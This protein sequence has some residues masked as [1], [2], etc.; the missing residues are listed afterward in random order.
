MLQQEKG[1]TTTEN[2]EWG[3]EKRKNTRRFLTFR[4]DL[5]TDFLPRLPLKPIRIK[6][7]S[8]SDCFILL[9]KSLAR[10]LR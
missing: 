3:S 8:I 6:W 9:Y 4:K 7:N 5:G 10:L 2:E 1:N